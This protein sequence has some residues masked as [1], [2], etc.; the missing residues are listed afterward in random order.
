MLSI[1]GNVVDEGWTGDHAAHFLRGSTGTSVKVSLARRSLQVP[2]VAGRPEMHPKVRWP[3]CPIPSF[4]IPYT[5]YHVPH[6][7]TGRSGLQQVR[8]IPKM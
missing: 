8:M 6:T 2:G 4:Y 3:A 1:D 5:L 7:L